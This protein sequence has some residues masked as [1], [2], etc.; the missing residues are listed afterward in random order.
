MLGALAG[1]DC[2]E[3][4]ADLLKIV[5]PSEYNIAQHRACSLKSFAIW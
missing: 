1:D 5:Q 3:K 4:P 2:E